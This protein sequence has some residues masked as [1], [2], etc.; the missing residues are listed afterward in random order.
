MNL[1]LLLLLMFV[2]FVAFLASY[3]LSML[4]LSDLFKFLIISQ[5]ITCHR[6][7]VVLLGKTG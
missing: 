4:K 5:L 6:V 3:G 1:S 2:I 7:I